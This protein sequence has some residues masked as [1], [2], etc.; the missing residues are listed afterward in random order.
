MKKLRVLWIILVITLVPY[1]A[2]GYIN[3]YHTWINNEVLTHTDLNGNFTKVNTALD[4]IIAAISDSI[5][6]NGQAFMYQVDFNDSVNNRHTIGWFDTLLMGTDIKI[7]RE[8][9]NRVVF[10][11]T[12][13]IPYADITDSDFDS[14]NVKNGSLSWSDLVTNANAIDSTKVKDGA[15]SITDLANSGTNGL[16]PK[17]DADDTTKAR[18]QSE[19]YLD[20]TNSTADSV[21]ANDSLDV[22][23][24]YTN[25]LG[26]KQAGFFHNL[27]GVNEGIS[28]RWLFKLPNQYA[29][30]DSIVFDGVWTETTTTNENY[31]IA[32]VYQDSTALR[33][34]FA[35]TTTSDTLRSSTAR[36]VKSIM[37]A[38]N[39]VSGT[40]EIMLRLYVYGIADTVL[41]I[42]R[43][44]VY[45]TNR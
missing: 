41:F 26:T 1:F 19:F 11:D 33:T 18:Y 4:E 5:V 34:K 15:L 2:F 35:A 32:Y 8:S 12:L 45:I 24:T 23:V 39:Y 27:A 9:A 20:Y 16:L 29:R 31:G 30:V 13:E 10:E 21:A 14:T 37:M 17:A 43:P 36:T 3:N 44:H 40:N 7:Y 38:P 6:D 42:S 25:P 22:E 28:L